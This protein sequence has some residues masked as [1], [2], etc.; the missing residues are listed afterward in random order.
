MSY[1]KCRE[2]A[3]LTQIEASIKLGIPQPTLA[4]WECGI[5]NPRAEKLVDIAKLYNCTTDELLA[6]ETVK[7]E[8]A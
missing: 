2:N 5:S 6:K 7:R 8:T 1:K 4:S 3:G